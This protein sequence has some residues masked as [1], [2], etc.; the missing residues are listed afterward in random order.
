MKKGIVYK[1]K[2]KLSTILILSVGAIITSCDFGSDSETGNTTTCFTI[3]DDLNNS[4]LDSVYL[5]LTVK[6]RETN[7]SWQYVGYTNSSGECCFE[8][9]SDFSLFFLDI[10]KNNYNPLYRY[11]E[12]LGYIPETIRL[13]QFAYLKLHTTNIPPSADNDIIWISYPGT[14]SNSMGTVRFEGANIDTTV[15]LSSRP[16]LREI[17]WTSSHNGILVDSTLAIN[18]QAQ[19]TTYVEIIY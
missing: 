18:I 13:T 5:R 19:D 8:Y 10:Q 17:L 1:I 7:V 9:E 4:P 16:G 14:G 12:V 11:G 3:V 6:S 2:Q 15:T